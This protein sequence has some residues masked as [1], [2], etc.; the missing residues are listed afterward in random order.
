MACRARI[1]G[2]IAQCHILS[3]PLSFF[4]YLINHLHLR[5]YYN[6]S[7]LKYGDLRSVVRTCRERALA[8]T[9]LEHLK[10]CVQIAR[11]M[12]YLSSLRFVH[13]DLA[14]RN[15]LMSS[16]N[17]VRIGDFG[18]VRLCKYFMIVNVNYYGCSCIFYIILLVV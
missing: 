5:T 17:V 12:E 4:I 10:L 7:R 3:F 8:L 13:M 1:H 15:C 2:G 18:L 9:Y 6:V 16:R 14:A 11:G